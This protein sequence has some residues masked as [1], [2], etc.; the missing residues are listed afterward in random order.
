MKPV[1]YFRTMVLV[2]LLLLVGVTTDNKNP[3]GDAQAY[4]SGIYS[5]LSLL[6]DAINIVKKN[7]VE[8]TD[9][10]ELIRGAIRGM[11]TS[12]DPHSSF[13]TP[14]MYKEM[15]IDTQGEFQGIGIT[16]GIRDGIL[17][18][19]APIDDTPA[20]RAGILSGDKIVKIEGTTTKDMSLME[21][22]KLMRGPKGTKVT[23]S[24]VREGVPEPIKHT[25]TRDVIPLYSVKV[26]DIDP[27]IG[28]V[29]IA[30][31]QKKTSS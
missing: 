10:Q 31:F 11:L 23:I 14:D 2:A 22:V 18:V 7:Y 6:T 17:T 19:I 27:N 21:A 1:R 9:V 28:D 16:I 3:I 15:K 29:R 20:F 25:I 12:L 26:K 24:I 5:Q 13:M 30:Q 4:N 8:E